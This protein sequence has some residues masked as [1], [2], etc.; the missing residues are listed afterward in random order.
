M[1]V[2]I[3]VAIVVC[4]LLVVFSFVTSSIDV[5][6]FSVVKGALVEVTKAICSWT[7]SDVCSSVGV[8]VLIDCVVVVLCAIGF[9]VVNTIFGVV[10]CVGISGV[11]DE[12]VL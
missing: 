9:L 7:D 6:E 10:L 12:S 2:S 1:V 8:L 11:V 5:V 4:I 3:A